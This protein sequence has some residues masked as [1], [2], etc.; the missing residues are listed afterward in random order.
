MAEAEGSC[1]WAYGMKPNANILYEDWIAVALSAEGLA[2]SDLGNG[3]MCWSY[4][5]ETVRHD[6]VI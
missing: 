6:F 5:G 4:F 2:V 3:E 1:T